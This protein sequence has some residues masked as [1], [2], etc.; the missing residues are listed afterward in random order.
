MARRGNLPVEKEV[1]LDER[2]SFIE[3]QDV[4][5]GTSLTKDNWAYRFTGPEG[6]VVFAQAGIEFAPE[7][8]DS[9]GSKLD[10]STRVIMQKCDKQGNL[11]SEFYVSELLGKFDYEQFRTDPDYFRHTVRDMMLD[12]R[13]I[14]KVMVDI[15]ANANGFSAAQSR[16]TIGDDTS[17]FGT[18]AE[19]VDH[20]DLSGAESQAV[21]TASKAAGGQ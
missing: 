6:Y 8:R 11:L 7:F 5:A 13:E 21:K 18:P 9:T 2:L 12:E 4:A 20:D 17:D 1:T 15:P 10:D 19:I 14:V 3:K 16:L